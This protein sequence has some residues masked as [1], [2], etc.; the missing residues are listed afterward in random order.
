MK[1]L[2]DARP[3]TIP[4]PGGVTRLTRSLLQALVEAL[5]A[6][7]FYFGTTGQKKLDLGI[8]LPPHSQQLHL[9]WPNK[10]VSSLTSLGLRSF[11]QF[12]SHEKP[13]LLILPNNG[14]VG[15]PQIPYG[16]IVHDLSFLVEPTWFNQRG[17]IWHTLV[18]ARRVMTEATRLFAVSDWTK[19]ALMLHLGIPA[20]KIDVLPIPRQ[21]QTIPPGPLPDIVRGKRYVLCL[22][23]KDTRKNARCVVEAVKQLHT[24]ADYQD[25]Y[26]VIVGGHSETFS[27]PRFIVL[28]RVSD[29]MLYALYRDA[30]AFLYPSWYEG[31]GLPLHEAALFGT[32]SIASSVTALPDTAPTGTLFA[33]PA[34]PQHWTSALRLLLEKKSTTSK[35][36]PPTSAH[37][38]TDWQHAIE[39]MKKFILEQKHTVK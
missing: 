6:E 2:F 22:G 14:H 31:L 4:S 20:E 17:R 5:P 13:D 38:S 28:P 33:S 9:G 36:S 19:F 11:E 16:L 18:H 10:C 3:L 29:E 8:C 23:R 35:R 27:D 15:F 25:L 7:T 34:K 30:A 32:P 39:P 26:L 1:I 21:P 24:Q 12:F 37:T